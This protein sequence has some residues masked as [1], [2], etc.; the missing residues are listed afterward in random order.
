M[1]ERALVAAVGR[2]RVVHIREAHNARPKRNLVSAQRV[3]IARAIPVFVMVTHDGIHIV[4]KI[5]LFQDV[6]AGAGMQFHDVPLVRRELIGFVQNLRRDH[7]LADIV[8]QCANAEPEDGVLLHAGATCDSASEVGD[9]F[10]MPLRVRVFFFDR[11]AP[12][13]DDVE[14]IALEPPDQRG[15]RGHRLI[16]AQLREELVR[17]I[18]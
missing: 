3:G 13:M 17:T 11:L 12:L 4:R 16:R 14:H 9:A 5:D 8:Q 15:D 1:R 7:D 6:C 2:E 10:A 18:Q